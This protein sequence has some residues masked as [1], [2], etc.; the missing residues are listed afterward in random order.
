MTMLAKF[1]LTAISFFFLMLE[2]SRLRKEGLLSSSLFLSE[3]EG[4][5][6]WVFDVGERG[7]ASY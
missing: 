3:E 4:L 6:C 5:I 2:L 1:C 7:A